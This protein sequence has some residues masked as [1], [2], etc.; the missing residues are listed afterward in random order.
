MTQKIQIKGLRVYGY[1]GV[2]EHERVD[3]QYFIVDASISIDADRATA[4]DDVANTVSYAEIAHLISE[5][6]RNNPVNLLETL[7]R[8]LADEILFAA[9]PWAKKVKI[10]VSKPDAPIDL[11][12]DTV[13]VTAKAKRQN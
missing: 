5:N 12:F 8:R 2:Q 4:T 1:H 6:V 10:T 9:S 11:Y 13:A 3:G 7:S